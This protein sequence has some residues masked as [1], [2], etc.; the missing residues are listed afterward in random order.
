MMLELRQALI[1][2]GDGFALCGR[3][4]A[5]RE[6]PPES[7]QQ[8]NNPMSR[9]SAPADEEKDRL[10]ANLRPGRPNKC[11]MPEVCLQHISIYSIFLSKRKIVYF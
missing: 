1:F 10:I 6:S 7:K 5:K 3:Q 11:K 4:A 8:G 2:L 9:G